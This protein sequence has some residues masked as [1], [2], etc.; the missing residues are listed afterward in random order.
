MYLLE[1]L[2]SE[3]SWVLMSARASFWLDKKNLKLFET[4]SF[5]AYLPKPELVP[6][7][8]TVCLF[9]SSNWTP[10]PL[11]SPPSLL[12]TPPCFRDKNINKSP[13]SV[14]PLP[15]PPISSNCKFS[16]KEIFPIG[17][18][19]FFPGKKIWPVLVAVV[20]KKKFINSSCVSHK[21]GITWWVFLKLQNETND[22]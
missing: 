19:R 15:H 5:H 12:T 13:P 2:L 20:G 17:K 10:P 14:K 1:R 8:V 9:I 18:D 11:L 7:T 4:L 6:P 22:V 3:C 16:H 21:N